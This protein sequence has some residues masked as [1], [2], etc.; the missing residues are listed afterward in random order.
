M[1]R[2]THRRALLLACATI[3][4]A[5]AALAEAP[6]SLE[7][8]A[9]TVEVIGT[10][11][12]PGLGVPVEQVPSNV[13]AVTDQQIEDRQS[14]NLP[15]LMTRSL[16]S[17]NVNEVTGN[18]YQADLNYR[19][20]QVS[21]LLG[22]PQGLSVFQDGVRLNEPFGDVVYWDLIPQQAISTIN[23]IPGSNPVF[24]LN[25]LG[26]ALSLRTKTGAHYPNTGIQVYGGSWDRWGVDA[27]HGGYTDTKDYH[28]SASYFEEDGWRDFSPSEVKQLFAK[29]GHE[30]AGNDL[31]LSFTYGDTDLTGNGVAPES[32]LEKRREQVFTVPDNTTKEMWMLNLTGSRVLSDTWQLGGNVYYR[33]NRVD[34]LNGDANDDYEDCFEGGGID[35]TIAVNNR[36]RTDEDVYGAALQLYYSTERHR[37]TLG[38]SIDRGESDFV[39]SAT[40]GDF[41]Q[42]RRVVETEAE[43]EE[44]ELEGSTTTWSVYATDTWNIA[45]RTHLTLSARY[46]YT[47]VKTTDLLTPNPP[48]LDADH[49]YDS[50]NPAI[51]V[52]HALAG[53]TVLFGGWSQGTRAPSPIELGCADRNNPCSLPNAMQADPF[54]D[55]V[56]ARTWE[57]GARGRFGESVGWVVSAFRTD[58]DDDILFVSTGTSAGFFTNFGETR[59]QGV[60]LGFTG[61]MGKWQWYANYAYIRATFESSACLL[62]ENNSTRGQ[63][64][65]CPTD[66]EILVSSGDSIPGIPEHQFKLGVDFRPTERLTLGVDVSAFSEQF[67]RG[68]ENN[69]HQAGTFTDPISNEA[70]TFEGSGEV[71]GYAVLNLTGRYRFARNWEVFARIDNLLDTEYET[72]AILA[73]NPFDANDQF[74]ADPDDWTRET[75]FA[76]GAPRAAWVGV[77]FAIDR[78]PRR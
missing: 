60:E 40:E 17:V 5:T 1:N 28:V 74:Q 34:T 66:D 51:G 6:V 22:T 46:N 24:G 62:S 9:P 16:P 25:T 27:E 41:D 31:D 8:E 72:A 69:Q 53:G 3:A 55:Q 45:A 39:Q 71:S 54:L 38:G 64:A 4:P 7:L 68:N 52:T 20:F 29:I 13:Q 37:L 11:P 35:C 61:T 43:E 67:A 58:N 32:M 48:N 50:L 23:L 2:R 73:E 57:L 65:Q 33:H 19:G 14:I 42:D 56:V 75:F 36:T 26:G 44:N 15:D 76:P 63:F 47:T 70:R 10:T 30:D 18:P 77:R 78:K 21:P 12:L 59:R 49:S